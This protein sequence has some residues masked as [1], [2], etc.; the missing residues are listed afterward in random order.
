MRILGLSCSPRRMGN[1]EILVS[2]VLDGAKSEGA[3][4]ELFSL[5]GKAIMPC[6]GCRACQS[7]GECH[8][9]DDIRALYDKLLDVDGIIFGTPIY[10]YSMAAQAKT[11]MDR[12]IALREPNFGLTNKVGAVVAVAGS[13]GVIDAIKDFY[14]YIALNHMIAA[15]YVFGYADE[16]G[17]IR[18]DTIVMKSAWE[19]GRE[20]VQLIKKRFEFPVEFRG[21][22]TNY[23]T[24][25]YNL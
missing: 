16:K 14:F 24:R 5:S 1:T 6:D 21:R 10:F 8:I 23:V 17:A 22:L 11:I 18:K 9:H 25:K 15:D 4:V 3:E 20:M 19:L 12:T 7:T 13:L 2:E